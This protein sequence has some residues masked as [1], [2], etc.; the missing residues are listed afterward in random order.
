VWLLINSV[1]V[2]TPKVECTTQNAALKKSNPL[3]QLK[4]P[5]GVPVITKAQKLGL[6]YCLLGSKVSMQAANKSSILA[7]FYANMEFIANQ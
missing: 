6:P 4:P 5:Y 3:I 1:Q 7:K 2:D